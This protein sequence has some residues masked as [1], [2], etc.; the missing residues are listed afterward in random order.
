MDHEELAGVYALADALLLPSLFEACP[1]P[2]LEA[3][4]TGCPIVTADRY[5]TKELAE[6]AAVLVN[7]EDVESIAG[8]MRRVLDDGGLRTEMVAAGRQRSREFT[9]RRCATETLRVFERIRPEAGQ[10][11]GHANGL[12]GAAVPK[13]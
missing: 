11:R 8:G 9:W 6:G 4:A 2:L 7:P 10:V 1:L 3:M 12:V 13:S 5:G